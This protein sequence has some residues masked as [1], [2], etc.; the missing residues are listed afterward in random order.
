MQFVEGVEALGAQDSE[1]GVSETGEGDVPIPALERAEFIISEA[2]FL[3][4]HFKGLFNLPTGTGD[5][6]QFVERG[7]GGSK[8]EVWREV[9]GF[10]A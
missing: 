8:A 1:E 4:G 9:I 10:G 5:M 6:H 3:L 7:T 2:N